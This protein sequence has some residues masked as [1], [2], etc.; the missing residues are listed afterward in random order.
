LCPAE[1][2]VV[3]G[4]ERHGA[5]ATSLSVLG[6]AVVHGDG[7]L[8]YQT[9][10]MA[11]LQ[12]K[13]VTPLKPGDIRICTGKAGTLIFADTARFFH[14]GKPATGRERFTIFYSYFAWRPR[15]LFLQGT[16]L[17]RGQIV[18][19]V[20]RLGVEQQAA[21]LW[22]NNLSWGNRLIPPSLI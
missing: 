15:H 22:R 1:A 19:L 17:S 21:A 10:T 7:S 6:L 2:A 5:F 20:E 4:I 18:Q 9:L 12:V 14:R 3:A 11:G 13:L 16:R 8:S